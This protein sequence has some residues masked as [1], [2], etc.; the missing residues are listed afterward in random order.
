MCVG[1]VRKKADERAE[2]KYALQVLDKTVYRYGPLGWEIN[3]WGK[4]TPTTLSGQDL[5]H[6]HW[7]SEAEATQRVRAS[8]KA[9]KGR[10]ASEAQ[11]AQR[12]IDGEESPTE[13][14]L[15]RLAEEGF[16]ICGTGF[17]NARQ[18]DAQYRRER[19]DRFRREREAI[20]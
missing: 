17:A 14:D 7:I 9:Q 8:I 12:R 20:A 6:L 19:L 3:A 11:H 10:E 2:R 4:W 18:R 5:D 15:E 13:A 1:G 16:S